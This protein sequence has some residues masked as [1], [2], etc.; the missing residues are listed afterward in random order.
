MTTWE[1]EALLCAC[2]DLDAE[3]EN[4]ETALEGQGLSLPDAENLTRQDAANV[5]YRLSGLVKA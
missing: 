2:L 3:P 5:L 4:L 1:A